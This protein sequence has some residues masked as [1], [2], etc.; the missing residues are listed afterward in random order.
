MPRQP[1]SMPTDAELTILRVLWDCGPRTVRQIHNAIKTQRGIGYTTTLRTVQVMTD[2]GLLLKDESERPQLYRPAQAE[3]QTQLQLVD[4][5]VQKAFG[6]S[7]MNL[8]LR[9]ASARRVSPEELAQV[10]KMIQKAKGER[11]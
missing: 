9:A 3:E 7:A 1:S 10:K 8:V 4:N 6:G 2:K 5:L 11:P